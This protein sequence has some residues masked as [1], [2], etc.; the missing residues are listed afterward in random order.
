M[1]N[2]MEAQYTLLDLILMSECDAFV[3]KF[4]SNMD[5]IAFALMTSRINGMAPYVS[6][7]S[8]WCADWGNPAGASELAEFNC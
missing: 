3:G 4:T 2:F 5:R 8:K 1:D 6:L 7:D